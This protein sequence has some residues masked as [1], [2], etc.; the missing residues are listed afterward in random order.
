LF[1]III[2]PYYINSS[3]FVRLYNLIRL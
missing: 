2:C 1:G 3:K